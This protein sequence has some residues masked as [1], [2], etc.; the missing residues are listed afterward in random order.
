MPPEPMLTYLMPAYATA[1]YAA[2][3]YLPSPSG[4][5]PA[6]LLGSSTFGAVWAAY[7]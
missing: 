1:S 3:L 5:F 4:Q 6:T 2:L 7:K